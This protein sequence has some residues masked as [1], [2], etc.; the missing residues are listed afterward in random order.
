MLC[1]TYVL[2]SFFLGYFLFAG[3][4]A[5]NDWSRVLVVA[6]YLSICLTPKTLN[7]AVSH[8][9]ILANNSVYKLWEIENAVPIKYRT[10]PHTIYIPKPPPT[11]T[12]PKIAFALISHASQYDRPNPC[13]LIWQ[14]QK[15]DGMSSAKTSDDISTYRRNESL[16]STEHATLQ[17][18]QSHT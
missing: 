2:W 12:K 8:Q 13:F 10:N 15:H 7:L 18:L 9:N 5:I 17:I 16:T 1:N 14:N 4:F 11:K 3:Y 6:T